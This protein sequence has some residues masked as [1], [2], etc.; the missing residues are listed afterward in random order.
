MCCVY[1]TRNEHHTKTWRG[2]EAGRVQASAPKK[3]PR[4]GRRRARLNCLSEKELPVQVSYIPLRPIKRD[5]LIGLQPSTTPGE[6]LV[7]TVS[8][9]RREAHLRDLAHRPDRYLNDLA[10]WL[11]RQI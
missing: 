10:R 5:G 9:L 11:E 3:K 6:V 1:E 2:S 4:S 7:R 8:L